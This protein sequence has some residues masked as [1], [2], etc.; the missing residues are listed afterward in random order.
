MDHFGMILLMVLLNQ[1]PETGVSKVMM[2]DDP[3][4][5]AVMM[6]RSKNTPGDMNPELDL[7]GICLLAGNMYGSRRQLTD[8]DICVWYIYKVWH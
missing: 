5:E 7:E 4:S 8:G 1:L 6:I 3:M 2:D